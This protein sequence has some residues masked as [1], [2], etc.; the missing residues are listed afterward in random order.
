[1]ASWVGH[2]KQELYQ[3]MGPPNNVTSDGGSGEI[4][5]YQTYV[6]MGQQ[7]GQ[8][9]NNG[10]GGVNYT[11]PQ[12]SGYTR[13]RMFYVNSNGVIYSWRWQGL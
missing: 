5:I 11:T 12:N 1:M 3:S 2:S 9:Y 4:L 10:Y 6:N 7:P 8:V 13:S